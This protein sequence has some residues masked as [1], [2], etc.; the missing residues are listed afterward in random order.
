MDTRYM[1][2]ETSR[3]TKDLF[4]IYKYTKYLNGKKQ[5]IL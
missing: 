2:Y 4:E 5:G 3:T 1:E